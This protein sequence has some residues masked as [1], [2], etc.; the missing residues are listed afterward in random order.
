MLGEVREGGGGFLRGSW[1]FIQN[2]NEA[3][4]KS[5]AGS[6]KTRWVNC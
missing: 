1:K 3:T 4:V 2:I 6:D 5:V